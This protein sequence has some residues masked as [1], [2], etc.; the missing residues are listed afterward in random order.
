MSK[1]VVHFAPRRAHVPPTRAALA[2]LAGLR[3]YRVVDE[4]PNHQPP[5]MHEAAEVST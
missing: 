3:G 2:E 5:K 1:N 4:Q